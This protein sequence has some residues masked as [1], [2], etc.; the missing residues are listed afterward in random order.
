MIPIIGIMV[1][2]AIRASVV[3]TLAGTAG[4]GYAM[5]RKYG[6]IACQLLDGFEEKARSTIHQQIEE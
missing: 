1:N 6:R 4:T 2:M 5:G 3:M